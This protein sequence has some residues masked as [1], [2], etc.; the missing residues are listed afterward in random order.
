[1]SQLYSSTGLSCPSQVGQRPALRS[2]LRPHEL[3][4]A[5]VPKAN[6]CAFT[7]LS[8]PPQVRHQ[9]AL[10]SVGRLHKVHT[11]GAGGA[12]GMP[13]RCRGPRHLGQ[14]DVVLL[15]AICPPGRG[16][17]RLGVVEVDTVPPLASRSAD[18]AQDTTDRDENESRQNQACRNGSVW[19]RGAGDRQA[20]RSCGDGLTEHLDLSVIPRDVRCRECLPIATGRPRG[21]VW[22]ATR[23]YVRA[24]DY[25]RQ[26]VVGVDGYL[27]HLVGARLHGHS[28]RP[29]RVGI[30]GDL[31][32]VRFARWRSYDPDGY[33]RR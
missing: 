5:G 8:G 16:T 24:V 6:A 27:R 32:L 7:G 12:H 19:D 25:P 2:D 21:W 13:P 28:G 17:G 22:T 20:R 14:I 9:P 33:C 31:Y 30:G 26:A 11:A 29:G 1:M 23:L 3:Q 10:R 15:I 18:P 4:T